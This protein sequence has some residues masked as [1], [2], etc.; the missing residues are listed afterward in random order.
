[1]KTVLLVIALALTISFS[2]SA[3]NVSSAT[4]NQ[5]ENIMVSKTNSS[6]TVKSGKSKK[7]HSKNHKHATT[8]K[9]AK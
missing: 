8:A 9:K 7:A 3:S 1:M 4:K 5:T 6:S 2:G